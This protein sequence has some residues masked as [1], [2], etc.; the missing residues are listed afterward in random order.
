MFGQ[1]KAMRNFA[2]IWLPLVAAALAVPAVSAQE[3]LPDAP[4]ELEDF[5]LDKP[6]PEAEAPQP[7][8]QPPA[9]STPPPSAPAT[10]QPE[11]DQ[12][13]PAAGPPAEATPV[14]RS[15]PSA[16]SRSTATPRPAGAAPLAA[17]EA[18]SSDIV[19]SQAG[20]NPS[21]AGTILGG[22]GL[23]NSG[24]M[25]TSPESGGDAGS[26][27]GFQPARDGWSIWFAI[28]A[29]AALLAGILLILALRR[30]RKAATS[31]PLEQAETE[32]VPASEEMEIEGDPHV[33]IVEP[34]AVPAMQAITRSAPAEAAPKPR[35]K[36]E[37]EMRFVPDSA[38]L[39]M[40]NL[41]LRGELKI[42]NL[43][44]AMARNVRLRT[45]AICASNSQ[46]AMIAAFN[47]GEMGPE[48]DSIDNI[49]KG[50]RVSIAI[51]VSLPRSELESYNVAGRQICVPIL[52]GEIAYTGMQADSGQTVHIAVMVGREANPPQD[53]MGPLRIDIGPRS[54]DALG[55]RP[56]SV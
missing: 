55:Q 1:G 30:Q 52:L 49:C 39:G 31:R 44:K 9:A 3:V 43:G 56:V 26:E 6:A 29:L 25:K 2:V 5:R 34:E 27:E 13:A 15:N 33:E 37:L 11:A 50:E 10:V 24:V 20:S 4:A 16:A 14:R 45:A 35:A 8:T 54:Y 28:A 38:T 36:P 21:A 32:P 23:Q 46:P 47:T 40:V 22:D 48:A 53:K 7:A 41:T 42:V 18:A 12:P 19:P 51:E 17:P